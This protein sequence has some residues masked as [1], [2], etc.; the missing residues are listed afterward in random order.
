MYTKIW[1]NKEYI[2]KEAYAVVLDGAP[3]RDNED[4]ELAVV[5]SKIVPLKV[6]V[7]VWRLWQNKI[8]TRD[9][10]IKRGTLDEAHNSCPFGCEKE[11][12][13]N[14]IFFECP[15]AASTWSAILRWLN[16]SCALHN[17]AV[18]NFFPIYRFMQWWQKRKG[19]T[20]RYLIL[21]HGSSLKSKFSQYAHSIGIKV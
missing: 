20:S 10:L 2:V 21:L 9:N 1:A 5:W 14:H 16:I 12:N 3:G 4:K 15:F 19:K 7:L 13:A 18:R 8:L 11:E 6:S 17:L